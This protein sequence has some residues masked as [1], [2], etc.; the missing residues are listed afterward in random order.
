MHTNQWIV[1]KWW[2]QGS[3]TYRQIVSMI[4]VIG[5]L[6]TVM[7]IISA[8][9]IAASCDPDCGAQTAITPETA[10]SG[11]R[12]LYRFL[13]TDAGLLRPLRIFPDQAQD[14]EN[15]QKYF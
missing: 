7:A 11:F 8:C 14:R 4:L 13:H 9:V 2:M 15:V 3:G 1:R 12:A 6:G 10:K 5:V